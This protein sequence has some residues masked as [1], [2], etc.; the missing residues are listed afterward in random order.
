MAILINDNTARVEYTAT[1]GQTTFTVP[2]EFFENSNLNVYNNGVE[3]TYDATPADASEYS[4]VGAGVTGGG[5]ITLGSPGAALNDVIVISRELTVERLTDF[6]LAGPF[7]IE[8]LNNDL[9]RIIVNLQNLQTIVDGRVFK[10]ADGDSPATLNELPSKSL[11]AG[12]YLVFDENGQAAVSSGSGDSGLRQDLADS[13]VNQGASLV[14]TTSGTNVQSKLNTIETN[15]TSLNSSLTTLSNTVSALNTSLTASIASVQSDADDAQADA[16]QALANAASAQS[17]AD[18]K[19]ESFYQTTMPSGSLGDFW[20]DTDDGNKLYRHNGSTFVEVQ[21]DAIATAISNAAGAQATA[22]GKITTFYQTSAPS[23]KSLGDLWI[24]TDGG[25]RLY[26][27]NGSSWIDVRDSGISTALSNAATALANAATAQSTA[28]GKIESFYQNTMPSGSVGDFWIDT[29]DGNKLYRHN[30]TT[31]V[32]IQ[33]SAIAT[34][35]ADAA[36]AQATA[37][38]KITTFYQTSAPS[39][40]SLGDLWIDT[41]NGNRLYRWNGSSWIDVRDSGIA[42][43]LANA[44]T[45]IASAA[46]A[47][48]TADGKIE[49]FYQTTMPTGSLGDFWVDTDDGNKLYRHNGST[50][51]AIQDSAIATAISNAATAQATADGKVTT[52]YSASAPT[53]EGVGDLWYDTDDSILYRWNGSN[54]SAQV[55]DVTSANQVVIGDVDPIVIQAD[56]T[57]TTTTT[58]PLSRSIKVYRG[59]T[60]LTSGVTVGSLTV[61]SGI[62][63]TASVSSG[64]VSISLTQADAAGYIVVPI[65]FNSVTYEKHI[66][67]SRNLAAPISGGGTGSASFTDQTWVNINT[68]SYTQVTDSGA[69]VQTNTS[70]ELKFTAN[71]SYEGDTA[72]RIQAQYSTDGSSWTAAAT[73]TGSTPMNIPG[74]EMSGFISITPTTITGLS[75]STD[76]YVRLVAQRT[77]SGSTFISWGLPTFTAQQP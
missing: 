26:R 62:A 59:G 52:F 65:T 20:I 34:A 25:N 29:D 38:G 70:G 53:A 57:G 15:I 68:T 74:E 39:I 58:L 24:D 17:T 67:I 76:Y 16:T 6:P 10:M 72:A 18:G 48:A 11:R 35:I 14:Q 43:A 56:S 46:T 40:K 77:T 31:F 75:A 13:T 45:A 30:G 47:Q 5:T 66:T 21:D 36:G 2:F 55:A 32:A 3:L 61:S 33:D 50:F 60:Q 63:A 73:A 12:K 54:W 44:A 69:V 4:V 49:S 28:D 37:D 8:S 22:D 42:T 1:A 19:I 64:V 71:A 41:D 9:D 7:N 51:V 23:I 27:W